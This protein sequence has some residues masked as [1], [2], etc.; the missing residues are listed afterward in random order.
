VLGAQ[1][2]SSVLKVGSSI[3]GKLKQKDPK[4]FILVI[5]CKDAKIN[6]LVKSQIRGKGLCVC[7]MVFKIGGNS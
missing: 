7:G 4:S 2:K 3:K 5:T 6:V 1:G